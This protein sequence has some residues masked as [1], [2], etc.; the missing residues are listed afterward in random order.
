MNIF[1]SSVRYPV[2]TIVRV[3]LVIVFGLVCLGFLDVELKP[4]TERPILVIITEFPGAAPE[5]V[6]GEVTN[7]Y[8]QAISGVSNMVYPMSFSLSGW[9]Y[10]V[11]FYNPGTNLDI[12]AAELQRNLDTVTDMPHA[13]QRPQIKKASDFVEMP[14]YQFAMTG[15]VDVVTMS[16]WADKVIAPAMKRIYGVGDTTYSGD[17]KREMRITFDPGRLKARKLTVEHIRD[18]IDRTNL[19]ESGGYFN[20][21]TREWTVRTLGELKTEEAFRRVIISRPGEP[22]MYLSDIAEI[23]DLYQKPDSYCRINGKIG[24]IFNV[25]HQVGANIVQ[26]IDLINREIETLQEKYSPLGARFER[27]YDQSQYIR[28]AVRIVRE[29]L[30]EAVLLVLLVLLA[31]LKNWRS[32][33]IVAISIPVS[34]IGTFVGMYLFKF[35]INVLSLAGLTLAIGMIVDDSIVVLEN[36]YRHRFE[37]GKEI[38]AACVEGTQEVGMAAFMCT[39]ATAA[40]FIPIFLIKGE[41]GTLFSPV[42]F[43]VTFA[44]FVSLL[45]AF[46]VVPMLASRWLKEEKEASGLT[47]KLMVPVN[48]LHS[49]GG[50]VAGALID[51]LKFALASGLRKALLIVAALGLFAAS[52]LVLPGLDYLPTGGTNLIQVKVELPA[53]T[54]LDEIDRLM[55]ILEDRLRT[56]KGVKHLV[57]VASRLN[58]DNRIFLICEPEEVSGVPMSKI[59][60]EAYAAARDLP[61][62]HVHPV[63]FPLFGDIYSRSNVLDLRVVGDS[64]TILRGIVDKIM[65]IGKDTQGV[66]FRYTD[67]ELHQ[68][69][70]D[71]KVDPI[72]AAT[73]GLTVRDVADAVKAA[74]EGRRTRTQYDVQ[75][76]YY[77]IRVMGKE[78]DVKA[79]ADVAR[80]NLTSPAQPDIQVPLHSVAKIE[81]IF[82]PLQITHLNGVRNCDVQFTVEGRSLQ[83]VLNEVV[84]KIRSGVPFPIG[85]RLMPFGA[86][87]SLQKLINAVAFVFPLAVLVV[88]LLLVMQLQSFVRPLSIILTVPLSITGANFLVKL[89]GVP[90]DSFTILGYIMMVGL[91]VK[92]AILLVTYAVQL[93]EEEGVD[94]D[95]A[96]ILASERR[97]RPIFMTAIAMIFGMLP[98]ALKSG[99]GSEI[100][101]GLAIAVIGGLSVATLFTLVFVPVVYTV[102]DDLKMRFWK[103]RPIA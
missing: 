72:R 24:L 21:G 87:E 81:T 45:D 51:C 55:R 82:G 77:Y 23:E 86:S 3:L 40:V 4:E 89:S 8:E 69:E 12:A 34:V 78:Q 25:F 28:D 22:A 103:I 16:T 90:F 29:C 11:V 62:K 38:V 26:S 37:E 76:R 18:F 101:N 94:R 27:L 7:R 1:E 98:L 67:L 47:K 61:F 95:Q 64:Y 14:V 2:T 50:V 99:A 65:E 46:T 9:S 63:Q 32:I 52:I 93:M 53:G 17:R 66:V 33:V 91:V 39:L 88:Y 43:I 31:F 79:V 100:Y 71:I 56:L 54:S 5:D 36:V 6:E 35:S 48:A 30:I 97:M 96:L 13:V 10:I 59:A 83:E 58:H 84:G 73:F 49:A 102:F 68:P 92:N 80:I 85:Y 42:A 19:N 74:I 41:I 70:V 75:G 44:V 15:D 20:Q 57:C 60:L